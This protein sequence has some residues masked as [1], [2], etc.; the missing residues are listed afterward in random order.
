MAVRFKNSRLQ[1]DGPDVILTINGTD[2]TFSDAWPQDGEPH[3]WFLVFNEPANTADLYV[4]GE[5]AEA[6]TGVSAQHASG[7][8]LILGAH[9]DG[10]DICDGLHGFH[11]LFRGELDEAAIS[12]L[13]LVS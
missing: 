10:G 4:D 9:G 8:T 5:L 7:Q 13:R 2:Y 12:S 6:K 3:L 11:T 1:V